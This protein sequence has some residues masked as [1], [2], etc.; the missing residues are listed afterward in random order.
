MIVPSTHE[1]TGIPQF[2]C[3]TPKISVRVVALSEGKYGQNTYHSEPWLLTHRS[4]G[5]RIAE[6]QGSMQISV[7]TLT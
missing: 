7:A 2:R 4:L 6:Q 1:R 3:N 5:E